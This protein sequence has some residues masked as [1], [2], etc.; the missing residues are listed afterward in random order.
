M[1]LTFQEQF[2]L[3]EHALR[4]RVTMGCDFVPAMHEPRAGYSGGKLTTPLEWLHLVFALVHDK[5]RHRDPGQQL[6]HIEVPGSLET[7][8]PAAQRIFTAAMVLLP[9]ISIEEKAAEIGGSPLPIPCE[10]RPPA[11]WLFAIRGEPIAARIVTQQREVRRKGDGKIT[12]APSFPNRS[13]WHS[14][15]VPLRRRSLKRLLLRK[16]LRLA[17]GAGL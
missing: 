15:P 5:H 11:P 4:F 17:D 16:S 12:K 8:I 2:D 14:A 3:F 7:A 13:P 9:G 1:G 6:A 10:S